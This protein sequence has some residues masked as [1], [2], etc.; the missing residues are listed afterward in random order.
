MQLAK[1]AIDAFNEI[2]EHNHQQ[3][4]SCISQ[5]HFEFIQMIKIS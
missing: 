3:Q 1:S 4:Q 5:I 2:M